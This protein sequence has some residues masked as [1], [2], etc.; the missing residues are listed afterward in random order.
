MKEKQESPRRRCLLILI[1]KI[2][3]AMKLTFL[4]LVISL[5]C[6]TAT[7][8]AQRV[9]IALENAK[10]EKVLAAITNQTGFNVAYSK[11]VVDVDRRIS[12]NFTNAEL[13]QVLDKLT[14]GTLLGYEVKGG[15]I[16]LFNRTENK[17]INQQSKKITGQVTDQNGEPIIGAN[18][19]VK[20]ST[21][22][23]ITDL[24]GNYS[25][26]ASSSD[27][28]LISY[29]GY[30]T[31]EIAVKNQSTVD[32]KLVEDTQNL[33]EVVVVGYG[34]QKKVNL[35]GAVAQVTAKELENRPVSNAT[36][37]LH[38]IPH[39]KPTN[40]SQSVTRYSGTSMSLILLFSSNICFV[41]LSRYTILPCTS[42]ISVFTLSNKC[43]VFPFPLSPTIN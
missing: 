31:K 26:E 34:V 2:P 17:P 11:Q 42:L 14:E 37:I 35:T 43:L 22:G 15:K 39:T 20:G 19:I 21:T 28:L 41:L 8:S 16:Y 30:N 1:E 24:D 5:L 13:S 33:D 10:V 18:V 6:F 3:N 27:I 4:F 40:S 29:I 32:I 38:I 7:A 9:S 25:I 23:T 36:Q 12:L